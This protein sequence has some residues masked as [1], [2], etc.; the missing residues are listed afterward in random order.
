MRDILSWVHK[1]SPIYRGMLLSIRVRN[2]SSATSRKILHRG[3]QNPY[4]IYGSEN[5]ISVMLTI[6]V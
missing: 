1:T 4:Y 5:L 2:F 6:A 3:V